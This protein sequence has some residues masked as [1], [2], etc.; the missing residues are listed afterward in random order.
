MFGGGSGSDE[1]EKGGNFEFTYP[2]RENLSE[3]N[4][5]EADVVLSDIED[6]DTENDGPGLGID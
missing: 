3:G 4:D 2:P 1:E 6:N 5:G